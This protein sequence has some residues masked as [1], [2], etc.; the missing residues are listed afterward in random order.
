MER[1]LNQAIVDELWKVAELESIVDWTYLQNEQD[2]NFKLIVEKLFP[3]E[4]E[5][6]KIMNPWSY[7]G[8]IAYNWEQSF[9]WSPTTKYNINWSDFIKSIDTTW[10]VRLKINV[11]TEELESIKG[12]WYY[13]D[14]ETE[15]FIHLFEKIEKDIIGTTK[16]YLL[17][18]TFSN[19]VFIRKLY[20][21]SWFDNINY[22]EEVWLDT[23]EETKDLK[24]WLT[25]DLEKLVL[26]RKVP[27]T[28]I[29]LIRSVIYSLDTKIATNNHNILDYGEQWTIIKWMNVD[30]ARVDPTDINSALDLDKLWKILVTDTNAEWVQPWIEVVKNAYDWIN[31]SLEMIERQFIQIGSITWIP[32]WAFTN[33]VNNG[34][35]SGVAKDKASTIFYKRIELYQRLV[36]EIFNEF[37]NI[38]NTPEAKRVLEFA[39]IVTTST[40]ELLEI[41]EKKLNNWLTSKKRAIMS[42]NKIDEAGAELILKEIEEENL[43]LTKED[44]SIQNN[45]KTNWAY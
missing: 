24:E 11:D 28:I 17:L 36:I 21:I 41:E 18:E 16:K 5:K 35:E 29:E 34:W 45:A 2:S 26:K 15:Y 37:W 4:V 9:F 1:I 12:H 7:A 8:S 44:D 10:E 14:W 40:A 42:I 27:F 3:W 31:I 38:V 20:K 25:I 43:L 22:W 32:S 6:A 13:D 30:S 19:K 39:E 33:N 23:L